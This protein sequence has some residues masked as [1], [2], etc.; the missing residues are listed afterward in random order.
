[1]TINEQVKQLFKQQTKDWDLLQQN[2]NGLSNI[3]TKVF[4][5]DGFTIKAQHN[6]KRITSS[7]AKTD[8]QSIEKRPCFLCKQNRPN[9][10]EAVILGDYEILCNP[11]P[12]FNEHFTISNKNHIPQSIAE[13]FADMLDISKAMSNY[14]VFYNGATCGASAPD[15]LHFQAGNKGLLTIEQNY[16]QIC[17]K[18]ATQL[19]QNS[20]SVI[21]SVNDGLRTFISIE[22]NNKMEIETEFKNICQQI[23]LVTQKSCMLNILSCYNNGSWRVLVFVR[24]KHRPTQFFE[25]GDKQILFSPASVDM[26]GVI[27]LP[28]SNDFANISKDKIEDMMQ[29]VKLN[30]NCFKKVVKEL[31]H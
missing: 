28:R 24:E 1:M 22:S 4:E 27:I 17:E 6:P 29:Q 8:K 25:Q 15:H 23:E 7:A 16:T 10:Q 3:Q 19:K 2:V 20:N 18:Y 13:P 12:I 5:F 11:F 30:D 21:L 26:G 14:V 9:V 31:M